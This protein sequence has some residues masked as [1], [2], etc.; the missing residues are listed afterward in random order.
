MLRNIPQRLKNL[1]IYVAIAALK[2]RRQKVHVL[3]YR[4]KAHRH[5]ALQNIIRNKLPKTRAL[6]PL[7]RR[8]HLIGY[9]NQRFQHHLIPI[10]HSN[11][12]LYFANHTSL[13]FILSS[14]FFII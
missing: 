8:R 3:A 9:I 6:K 7:Q 1:E 11:S 13:L 14:S 2:L 5:R 4:N 10:F 12:F